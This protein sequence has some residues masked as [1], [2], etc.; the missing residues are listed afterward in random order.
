MY[1]S[2]HVISIFYSLIYNI[3]KYYMLLSTDVY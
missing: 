1:L 3:Y 2:L